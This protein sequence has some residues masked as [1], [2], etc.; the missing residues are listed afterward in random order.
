MTCT[1]ILKEGMN[2]LSREYA[3]TSYH[4]GLGL[5]RRTDLRDLAADDVL[6]RLVFAA[7]KTVV[8]NVRTR[9]YIKDVHP[10]ELA[11]D[12]E[13]E[14]TTELGLARWHVD[15]TLGRQMAISGA[16]RGQQQRTVMVKLGPFDEEMLN[17]LHQA[18]AAVKELRMYWT[19]NVFGVLPGDEVILRNEALERWVGRLERVRIRVDSRVDEL[20][21]KEIVAGLGER[22]AKRL[23]ARGGGECD[24]DGETVEDGSSVR[25]T[26][27]V[28]NRR[29]RPFGHGRIKRY[30]TVERSAG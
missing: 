22:A 27:E 2:V 25:W 23:V 29:D 18:G 7:V 21:A 10:D 1:Q 14:V 11:Q 15:P 19:Y 16:R 20:M 30:V 26:E 4:P 5:V 8:F 17:V 6:N 24:G 12:S 3:F 13:T 9:S 28:R